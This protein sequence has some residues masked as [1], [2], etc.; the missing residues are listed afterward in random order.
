VDQYRFTAPRREHG[1]ANVLTVMAWATDSSH[2]RPRLSLRTADGTIIPAEVLVTSN[3]AHVLQLPDALD[4]AVY[5]VAVEDP[6][7]GVGDYFLGIDFNA[8]PILLDPFIEDS[9]VTAAERQVA[10]SLSLRENRLFHLVLS[11]QTEGA[12]SSDLLRLEVI[13]RNGDTVATLLVAAGQTASTT[14]FLEP[15]DYLFL[16]GPL[17]GSL[18]QPV[19][20]SLHGLGLSDPIGPQPADGASQPF[21]LPADQPTGSGYLWQAGYQAFVTNGIPTPGSNGAVPPAA[22]AAGSAVRGA[23]M[24]ARAVIDGVFAASTASLLAAP[25]EDMVVV[26]AGL[27]AGVQADGTSAGRSLTSPAISTGSLGPTASVAVAASV[28]CADCLLTVPSVDRPPAPESEPLEEP[29]SATD[30]SSEQPTATDG[31]AE[32]VMIDGGQASMRDLSSVD[33]CPAE[34]ANEP[35]ARAMVGEEQ[36]AVASPAA[37]EEELGH[38]RRIGALTISLLLGLLGSG[39]LA[40]GLTSD[41]SPNARRGLIG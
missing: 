6:S 38:P 30:T 41:Q 31:R 23:E 17:D 3:G 10:G 28:A 1:Q 34:P 16:V 37:A 26:L 27:L 14:V 11:S 4:E 39:V 35:I 32:P 8:E 19:T 29:P 13:A 20:Y 22:T 18:A 2:V 33:R 15:G 24:V 12:G 36:E 9:P 5:Q 40:R 7:G 21:P 25:S